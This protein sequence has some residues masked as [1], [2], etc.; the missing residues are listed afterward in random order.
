VLLEI[1]Q[2]LED[3][4]LAPGAGLGERRMPEPKS[5]V[6]EQRADALLAARRQMPGEHRVARIER[7]A[8]RHRLAVAHVVAREALQLVRR[9]VSVIEGARAAHL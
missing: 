7:H 1:L 8:D 4:P 5:Q 2:T 6:L 9:P 3:R